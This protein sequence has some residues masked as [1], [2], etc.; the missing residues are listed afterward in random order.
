VTVG[1]CAYGTNVGKPAL[2]SYNSWRRSCWDPCTRGQSTL[3]LKKRHACALCAPRWLAAPRLCTLNGCGNTESCKRGLCMEEPRAGQRWRFAPPAVTVRAVTRNRA[4]YTLNPIL[5]RSKLHSAYF[6]PPSL[7]HPMCSTRT[8]CDSLRAHTRATVAL[9][10]TAR[11][12]VT[13]E[14]ASLSPSPQVHPLTQ[15]NTTC[16]R[17]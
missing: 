2:G 9:E 4:L 7:A 15:V 13:D 16:T 1:V 10:P 12:H 11:F 5:F 6:V 8:V 14:V 17:R 3:K